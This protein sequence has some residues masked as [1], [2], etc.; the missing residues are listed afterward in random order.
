MGRICHLKKWQMPPLQMCSF[1]FNII[2][3]WHRRHQDIK[4]ITMWS[5]W[6]LWS[7]FKLFSKEISKIIKPGLRPQNVSVTCIVCLAKAGRIWPPFI[8]LPHWS[9]MPQHPTWPFAHRQSQNKANQPI[10]IKEIFFKDI[11]ESSFVRYFLC[12]L[13]CSDLVY[14]FQ[15][16]WQTSMYTQYTFI[17]DLKRKKN[18]SCTGDVSK[19]PSLKQHTLK[20]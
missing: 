20:P 19:S 2:M 5:T 11:T 13:Y 12:P 4:N 10:I 14:S 16:R 7:G 17:Y 9:S 1:T 8:M 15:V 3:S 6:V 18:D